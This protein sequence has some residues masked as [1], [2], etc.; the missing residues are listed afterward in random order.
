MGAA[1]DAKVGAVC[2]QMRRLAGQGGTAHIVKGGELDP[3][4]VFAGLY[5][6]FHA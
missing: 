6:K 1:H 4:G 2:A 3:A 5:E